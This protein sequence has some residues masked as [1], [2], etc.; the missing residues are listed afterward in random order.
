[1]ILRIEA[2]N[3]NGYET[4]MEREVGDLD[5]WERVLRKMYDWKWYHCNQNLVIDLYAVMI[6]A[7]GVHECSQAWAT[8]F[9]DHDPLSP[10]PFY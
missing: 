7:D 5:N 6:D 9:S 8:E 3:E 4:L 1:M 2:Y 10:F